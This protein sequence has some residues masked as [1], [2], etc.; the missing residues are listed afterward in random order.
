MYTY[1]SEYTYMKDLTKE[2]PSI[3]DTSLCLSLSV[4][5]YM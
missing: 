1:I 2:L 3:Y 4:Y 5:V